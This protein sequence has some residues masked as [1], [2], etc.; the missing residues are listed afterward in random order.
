MKIKVGLFALAI[1][2]LLFAGS[3]AAAQG[4]GTSARQISPGSLRLL[5]YY[6]GA[7][8]QDV[9]FRISQGQSCA[10]GPANP[11]GV[12]FPCG[13][14]GDVEASGRGGALLLKAVY[15]P[16]ESFQ[17]YAFGGAGEYSLSVPSTTIRNLLTGD[18]PGM[19]LGAGLKAVLYPETL[20]TP[21][22]AVDVSMAR[23][24]YY[25]NRRHPG[26]TPGANNN[27]EQRLDLMQYQVAVQGSRIFRV[28]DPEF[29]IEPYGGIKWVR[30]QSDLK[31]LTDGSHAGGGQDRVHPFVGVRIPVYKRETFFAEA[32][33][34]GVYQ[35][36]AGMEVR[37]GGSEG[38]SRTVVP[39]RED[40]ANQPPQGKMNEA[41]QETKN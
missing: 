31:D 12:A 33:F 20:V 36:A 14:A 15:Q 35:Y 1:C 17:Y 27:I 24:R 16:W 13:Q 37:F 23:H 21:A 2:G 34:V 19:I 32:A 28:K 41:E 26:G 5:A 10:A 29:Q 9:N 38:R 30:T 22:I 39:V 11:N 18:R 3:K 8:S 7:A 25:F 40:G 6:Q 4:L